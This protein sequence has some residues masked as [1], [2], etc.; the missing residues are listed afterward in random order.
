MTSDPLER[1]RVLLQDAARERDNLHGKLAT[2]NTEVHQLRRRLKRAEDSYAEVS[3]LATELKR[4]LVSAEQRANE[5][6]RAM[7]DHAART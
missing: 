4:Q 1:I 5:S 2:A 6:R 3:D 7:L